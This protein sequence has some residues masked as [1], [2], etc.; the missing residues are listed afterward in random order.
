MKRAF[1]LLL[2]AVLLLAAVPAPVAAEETRTGGTVV[3]EAD[4]TVED[5]LTIFA[6]TAVIRGTVEGDLTVFAGNVRVDGEV[7]GDFDGFAGNVRLNGTVTGDANA[8]GGNVFLED[9]ARVGGELEAAAG[10]VALEGEVGEDA[11]LGAG[12]VTV[13]STASVGG[14]LVYGGDLDLAEGASVGGEV[15]ESDDLEV[16]V[17]GPVVP[18]W[19][20]WAYGVLVNLLLG[21]VVL[22]VFPAFSDDLAARAV[23]D[24]VR[25]GGVG[26]LLFVAVPVALVLLAIT[27]VGIPLSL[28]GA[29]LYAVALWLGTVYGSFAVGTWLVSLADAGSRW[30][31]LVVGVVGVALVGRVPFLGGLVSFLV[32]LVGLGA[33]ALGIRNRYRN[34]RSAR[35]TGAPTGSDMP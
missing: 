7:G 34:R 18:G 5:D 1:A 17:T 10:N 32:L 23:D 21:A 26:L 24:P 9:G 6:G 16:G 28:F 31:A 8:V 3:V 14:D 19:L 27:I 4:E 13:A 20:G 35:R 12:T 25:T 15:R 29:L 11:R 33:L 30:L 22:L 2:V